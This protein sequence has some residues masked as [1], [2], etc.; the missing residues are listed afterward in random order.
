MHVKARCY[1]SLRKSEEPHFLAVIF[2]KCD[3]RAQVFKA[4]CSCKGGSS[5]H[6]NHIL[7]VD[8]RSIETTIC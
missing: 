3:G 4:H 8:M 2:M 5:G 6:C 1:R 7:V